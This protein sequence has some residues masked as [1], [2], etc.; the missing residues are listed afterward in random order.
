MSTI[1]Y[2]CKIFGTIV[3]VAEI[4]HLFMQSCFPALRGDLKVFRFEVEVAREQLSQFVHLIARCKPVVPVK[5]SC[6]A[7]LCPFAL[8][9]VILPRQEQSSDLSVSCF[10]MPVAPINCLVED[11]L[12]LVTLYLACRLRSMVVFR[13]RWRLVEGIGGIRG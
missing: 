9:I 12:S 2:Y 7:H 1:I 3:L 11:Y 6:Y 4:G 13:G 5:Q 8:H 10:P